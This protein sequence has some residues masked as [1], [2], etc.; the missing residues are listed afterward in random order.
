MFNRIRTIL[1]TLVLLCFNHFAN[2]QT[3]I[4]DAQGT[5]LGVM[6]IPDGPTLRIGVEVFKRADNQ[7]GANVSSLDQM[8]R[9]MVSDVSLKDNL[10]TVQLRDAPVHITGEIS[11]DGN[12]IDAQ[13]SQGD[14]TWSL[15]LSKVITLPETARVQTPTNIIEYN[16]EAVKYQNAQDQT[17]LAATLTSPKDS[18]RHPAVM[19]IAGSG[20]NQRD[21]YH[22]GHRPFKVL[23]DYLTRQ[24][25]VVLRADKRGVY[26]SAG[27]FKEG[28]VDNFAHDTQAAIQF[29]KTNSHVDPNNIFLIGHSEG[30]FIAAMTATIEKVQGIVSMAGPGMSTLD[31][32]L[33]QDQTE[34]AA[35][36]ASKTETDVLLEF[37][38]HFYQTVLDNTDEAQRKQQLQALYDNLTG[39]KAEIINKWAG[40]QGTLNVDLASSNTFYLWL[41]QNPLDYWAK[42]TIPALLLNGEKDSQVPA[43]ENIEGLAKVLNQH[44]VVFKQHIFPSLNHM[45]QYAETGATDE[46]GSIEETL[47]P[48]VLSTIAEWLKQKI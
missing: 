11:A 10:F 41:K 24:G 12:T 27:S 19:L 17:W 29:L 45:F 48:E 26:Q 5:W 35:K 21:S 38:Q 15:P 31:I 36:G 28:D 37:S 33:L 8:S 14:N 25:F 43:K 39:T 7:W 46:Y 20:P 6:N 16:E 44:K 47:N 1:I 42:L 9:Y 40:Q 32:L 4:K 23:A 18:K 3:Q 34:P 13:F 30:S 22:S 2:A